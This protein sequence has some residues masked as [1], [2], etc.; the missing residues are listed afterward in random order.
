VA[1]PLPARAR[2][3]RVAQWAAVGC[4]A[5]IARNLRGHDRRQSSVR[6]RRPNRCRL[7][8]QDSARSQL[9]QVAAPEVAAPEVAAWQGARAAAS[10]A[11]LLLAAAD[12]DAC[13]AAAAA[14]ADGLRRCVMPAP[15]GA[16][17]LLAYL[18]K[19][20]RWREL[21]AEAAALGFRATSSAGQ[22][23][24]TF[25]V[26]VAVYVPKEARSVATFSPV[27]RIRPSLI[28][29]FRSCGCSPNGHEQHMTARNNLTDRPRKRSTPRTDEWCQSGF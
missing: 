15:A 21:E 16:V 12:P 20:A 22:R 29:L 14:A 18:T 17:R 10:V 6:R 8:L 2:A 1:H 3:R 25:W 4:A 9:A 28:R 7:G 24:T 26:E 23:S 11:D 27:L 19:E 13:S 5:A